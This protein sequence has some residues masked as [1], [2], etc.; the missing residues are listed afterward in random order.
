MLGGVVLDIEFDRQMMGRRINQC[1]NDAKLAQE[2][3]AEMIGVSPQHLSNIVNNRT[4][5]SM[6]ILLRIATVLDAD[7]NYLLGANTT[8]GQLAFD[9][10]ISQFFASLSASDKQICLALC[11]AYLENKPTDLK[12]EKES[13]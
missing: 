5:L 10:Q 4:G 8:A 9:A 12:E 7:L 3:L 2:Q 11:R 1:R 6:T 13:T